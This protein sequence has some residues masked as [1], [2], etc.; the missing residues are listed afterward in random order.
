MVY[1]LRHVLS[2]GVTS[3]NRIGL[4]GQFRRVLRATNLVFIEIGNRTERR[5]LMKLALPILLIALF[6]GGCYTELLT[7]KEEDA[8]DSPYAHGGVIV[9]PLPPPPPVIIIEVPV[10]SEPPHVSPASM[11]TRRDFGSTRGSVPD[12]TGSGNVGGR[13]GGRGR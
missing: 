8:T 6:L 12:N 9:N 4:S 7:T 5:I 13:T 1:F 10:P 11:E 2:V 3:N